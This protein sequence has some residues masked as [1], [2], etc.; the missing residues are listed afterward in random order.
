MENEQINDIQLSQSSYFKDDSRYGPSRGRLNIN[1]WPYGSQMAL[2]D[3]NPWFQIDLL[4][5]KYVTGLATQGYNLKSSGAWV[6]S[7]QI[8]WSNDG[9]SWSLY[10]DD[11]NPKVRK[12]KRLRRSKSVDQIV[13]FA[14]RFSGRVA[15][16]ILLARHVEKISKLNKHES[17]T[18]SAS[19]Q[20]LSDLY[21]VIYPHLFW[22]QWQTT[23][24]RKISDFYLKGLDLLM[25]TLSSP[26][27]IEK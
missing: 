19:K 6:A 2:N 16:C 11:E 1:K 13:S 10:H 4:Q 23:C 8:S 3:S 25:F 7:Y 24:Q 26:L 9:S 17:K 15:Q 21:Y 20:T 14:S 18:L 22:R 27:A 12:K 5:Q